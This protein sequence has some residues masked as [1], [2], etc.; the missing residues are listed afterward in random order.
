[1]TADAEQ[2]VSPAWAAVALAAV[3]Q[4][5]ATVGRHAGW[6]VRV[7]VAYGVAT[8][9]FFPALGML[10][11]RSGI[12]A[13]VVWTGF[14]LGMGGYALSRRVVGHGFRLLY[15]TAAGAWT[16]LWVAATTLGHLAFHDR[17]AYWIAAGL[18]VAIPMAI[19]AVLA[20]RRQRPA[21]GRINP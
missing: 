18:I 4:S 14:V 1:M 19:G 5:R 10:H 2:G 15:L 9:V 6:A 11:G 17:L 7:L 13:G 16:T 12:L 20:A 8:V 21:G 3:D